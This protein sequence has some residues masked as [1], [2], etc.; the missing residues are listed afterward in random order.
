MGERLL[1]R[2]RGHLRRGSA[3]RNGPPDEVRI[4]RDD[5]IGDLRVQHLEDRRMLGIDRDHHR[6][7]PAL[8][9]AAATARRRPGFPCWPGPRSPRPGRRPGSAPGPQSRRW[10]TSPTGR[11]RRPHRRSPARRRPC[12]IPVP[13]SRSRSSGSRRSSS[14]TA[15]CGR[16]RSACS[17]SRATLR[18]AVRPTTSSSRPG[19]FEELKGRDPDRARRAQHTDLARQVQCPHPNWLAAATRPSPQQQTSGHPPGRADPPWP[20]I[21]SPESFTPKRRLRADSQR[22]PAMVAR[23]TASPIAAAA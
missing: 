16:Q 9:C 2:R 10:P 1:R 21:R 15:T 6:R 19:Q 5:L 18:P 4:R 13:F 20:G 17:A 23:P 22:S 11:R 12:A 8:R 14:I 3:S 7:L